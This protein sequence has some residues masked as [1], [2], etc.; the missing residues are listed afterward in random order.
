VSDYDTLFQSLKG[1]A[2]G[3]QSLN[4][5]AVREYAPVVEGILHSRSL[6]TRQ[7]ERTLDGLLDLC[8]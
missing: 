2:E 8:G 5:Q 1:M 6:D 4:Q 3:L 7:I